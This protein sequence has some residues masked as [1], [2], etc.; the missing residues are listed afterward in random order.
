MAVLITTD[1]SDVQQRLGLVQRGGDR[2]LPLSPPWHQ[3]IAHWQEV[4]Y[5]AKADFRIVLLDD[6]EQLLALLPSLLAPWGWQLTPVAHPAQLWTV[7]DAVQPHLLVLDVEMPGINGLDLCQILRADEHW[8]QLP[9]IFLTAHGEPRI[10][11]Q[12]FDVGAD[13]FVNK[14]NLATE[15]PRR[16]LNRLRRSPPPIFPVPPSQFQKR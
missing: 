6:D 1:I 7:L 8:R 10:R 15:L 3:V 16:I 12:A 4:L 2:L 11:H 5:L 13:D 14:A 9:I